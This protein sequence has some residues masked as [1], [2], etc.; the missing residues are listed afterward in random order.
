[1]KTPN[2]Q[3]QNT[4]TTETNTETTN[5]LRHGFTVISD[6]GKTRTAIKIR[7]N[8]EW[9][10]GRE[11]FS[12][13]ADVDEKDGRG[14]WC[15]SMGGCCHEHIL[16]LRPDLAPF[17]ALHLSDFTG[18]PMHAASNAFY[19]FAGFNGGLGQQYH[20]GS[21]SGGKTPDECRRIFAE[22]IR[23]TETEVDEIKARAPRTVDEL[24]F[25]IEQM[26][27]PARWK[28]EADA[29]ISQLEEWTGK[30][31]QPQATKEGFAPLSDEAKALIAERRASGYYDAEQVAA[32]DEQSRIALKA[33]RIAEI[34]KDHAKSIE[35]LEN[36]RLV[37]LALAE[38]FDGR[39]NAIYYGHTGELAFNWSSA[40]KLHTRAEFDAF[41]QAVDASKMPAGLIY[42][43][44][45]KP[46]Y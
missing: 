36:A 4:M 16:K 32:R 6:G 41:T 14:R 35:K 1:M 25:I 26:E 13:T 43:F 8:D 31:F 2:T 7:L 39:A 40:E 44:Q 20:G 46:K 10:N 38:H 21:G 11:D 3:T 5:N 34:E 42:R 12:I 17:V 22:H 37:A 29:A 30:R 15:E 19:W 9:K 27:F 18:A 45:E 28:A 24:Q 33:A 23:A